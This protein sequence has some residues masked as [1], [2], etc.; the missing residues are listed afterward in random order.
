V[1][2][3]GKVVRQKPGAA[4]K[5]YTTWSF[6][7]AEGEEMGVWSSLGKTRLDVRDR[8]RTKAIVNSLQTALD[9]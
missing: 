9:H 1:I 4:G 3:T 8:S 7:R 2:Q 6:G 5:L